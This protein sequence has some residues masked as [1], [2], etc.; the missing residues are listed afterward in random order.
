MYVYLI[1]TKIL[2]VILENMSDTDILNDQCKGKKE[3]RRYAPKSTQ[4]RS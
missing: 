2:N 3:E 1:N 4:P